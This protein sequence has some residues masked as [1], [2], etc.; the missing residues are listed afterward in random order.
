MQLLFILDGNH[1]M[2]FEPRLIFLSL[3]AMNFNLTLFLM[4]CENILFPF[5]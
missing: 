4:I 1:C 2:L 5:L 3:K